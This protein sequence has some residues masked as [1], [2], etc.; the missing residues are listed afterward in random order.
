[1]PVYG[2][3]AYANGRPYYAMRFIRGDSLKDAIA[4][5]HKVAATA[6]HDGRRRSALADPAKT[7]AF[8]NLL[9]R[10][11]D[12]CNAMEYAHSRGVLHRDL[13][14][15]NIIVGKYGETL[16]VDWGLAKATGKSD[17]TSAERTLM[18]SSA[19]GS[20][21]TVPGRALG[22]PAYMGPEQ[23]RGDLAALGPR[24][25]VYSLGATLYCLL[26]GRPPFEGG[27]AVALLQRVERGAFARPR[28]V[29]PAI[30]RALEAIVL[31][32][33]AAR[34]EDRY[35]SARA[36][37]DDVEDWL[38][39]ER[40][41]A[42]PEPWTR[43]LTRWLTR[44]RTPVT[45]AAA[46]L[47]V[48]LAGLGLVAAV[49]TRA[50]ADLDRKNGE[51]TVANG[52]L[53]E[54][55]AALDLQR[56]RAEDREQQAIEAVKRFRDAVA[57]N[58]RL[59]DDPELEDLR[60]ALLKEPLAFFR[61][62]RERLQ[63]DRDTRPESLARLGGAIHEYAHL[64]EEV[65]DQE[66]G[67]RAHEDSL[68]IWRGL[69]RDEPDNPEYLHGLGVIENCRGNFLYATGEVAAARA[70]YEA[71]LEI[72]ER[73]A[74]E[75][76]TVILYQADLARSHG[77]LGAL[78]SAT[79]EPA[80]A[81]RA[82]E[83]ALA[84]FERLAREHPTVTLY[85]ADLAASHNYLG[86]LLR[87]TGEVAGARRAHEV[88]LAIRERLAREHPTVILYQ[89]DLARSHGNLGTLF[90]DTGEVAGARA[91]FEAALAIQERLAREHP[92][93]TRYQLDLATSHYNL[94]NLRDET[95]VP[96]GARAA[97]EAALAIQER[98]AREHPT[99]TQYQAALATSHLNL[100]AL[101]HATG[102]PAGARRAFAAALA[103]QE[104][105][106]REHPE[107]P[108]YASMPGATLNNLAGLD[109]AADRSAEARDRLR[110]AIAW[111][112][113]ALAANPRNPR[114]RQ[115]LTDYY[116]NLL[117][118]AEGLVDANLAAE[119]QSGLAELA[120]SDPKLMALDAR[121]AAAL[122]GG[123][124]KDVAERLA[125]AKR[126]YDTKRYAFA[127]MLWA[128]AIE[129]EP[130]VVASRQPQHRYNAACAAV[131]AADGQG[132]DEPAPD[133]AAKAKLREQALAWLKA[134][135][136]VWAKFL[137]TG[138][139]QAKEFI[140][141]TLAHWQND[142]ELTGVREAGPLEKLPEE[143]RVAWQALWAE[144]GSQLERA[145]EKTP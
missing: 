142:T 134:E 49:Q 89:A 93:V 52:Q 71:A 4:A 46:A 48:G 120:A 145:R 27:D 45:G 95:G 36:L 66:D 78:L 7:V 16:V 86:H 106:A 96:A 81:R 108:D 17:P 25:D 21:E 22:T 127:A 58:P 98:L 8:R 18:P 112:K 42:Y 128:E 115:S 79:G 132:R 3:G 29:D 109:Q 85:Q 116:D 56:T 19:S 83:V 97:F 53:A 62:L 35:G 9:R 63:A 73:L 55:N 110:E 99:V 61:S 137:E 124:P 47:L 64:T 139:P 100:G 23:A 77:N 130:K 68:A 65:G 67:L 38:A 14:P 75:H 15:G 50:R 80:G 31:K 30:D 117:R 102:D 10:F 84:I 114:Y 82:H 131:L 125:L 72:R 113:K 11:L 104:R 122:K 60:K 32:A 135:L 69:A 51:L 101:L 103:I 121:L 90:S 138:Q 70:A 1:V 33:M 76:P 5:F 92:T 54:S 118:L 107:A 119:A 87:A 74:R 57:D 140:A 141:R 133:D 91:A 105:L 12:V 123:A 143:E 37:A 94:G 13:K 2:L 136:A 28:Q 88:A 43:T 44:H 41:E 126:A 6:G 39:D 129:A 24:S 40:V 20:A 144:V 26:T 34:P 59:K 111:Q